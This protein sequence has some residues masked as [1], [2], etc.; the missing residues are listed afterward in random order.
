[1]RITN[2]G[3]CIMDGGADDRIEVVIS[4]EHPSIY[5]YLVIRKWEGKEGSGKGGELE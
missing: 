4:C 3:Q 1:M 2:A 5:L